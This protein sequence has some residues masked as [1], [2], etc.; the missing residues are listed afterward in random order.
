MGK[1]LTGGHGSAPLAEEAERQYRVKRDA[2]L[3]E[4]IDALSARL[5]Q[6]ITERDSL[7][8]ESSNKD[9]LI[10]RLQGALEG[11]QALSH[12]GDSQVYQA[13]GMALSWIPTVSTRREKIPSGIENYAC[14]ACG[15]R[16]SASNR[17]RS[18][19]LCGD[20]LCPDGPKR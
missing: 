3:Q 4:Q 19:C 20:P 17:Q 6:V 11:I 18:V 14:P 1:V 13:A 15:R 8:A 9:L 2:G 5:D 7:S 16:Y 10:G 12:G